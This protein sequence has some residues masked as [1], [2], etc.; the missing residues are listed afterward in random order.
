MDDRD[1]PHMSGMCKMP[2]P[3]WR[4]VPQKVKLRVNT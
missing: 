4:T 3:V 1:I 2:Y